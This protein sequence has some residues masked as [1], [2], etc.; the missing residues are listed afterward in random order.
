MAKVKHPMLARARAY[1]KQRRLLGYQLSDAGRIVDFA[2]FMDRVD[3]HGPLT[4]SRVMEWIGAVKQRKCNTQAGLLS[5]IRG[6][7]RY[8]VGFDAR[9]QVPPPGLLG[10]QYSR[11]R[12]HIFTQAQIRLILSRARALTPRTSALF[13]LTYETLI[14]LL[15]CTG[16]R[17]G[18]ARRLKPCDF[19]A[20]SGLLRVPRFKTSPERIIPL[21]PSAV[22]ALQRYAT[23]RQTQFP[24]AATFFVGAT[25]RMLN[26]QSTRYYFTMLSAGIRPN[27]DFAYTHLS[28]LRH[29]FASGWIAQWGRERAV[30]LHLALL[31]R[32]LGHSSFASTWWYVIA[33]PRA[34][35]EASGVFLH[36]HQH[37][38]PDSKT[39]R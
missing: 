36:F 32:Y 15:A 5:A 25:G 19:D 27:G 18:E 11:M 14:G 16:M 17:S 31:S 22:R 2:N 13:A 12:P 39:S 9:T 4:V 24:N 35:Q 37:A 1:I 3:P 33:D 29:S 6:F 34:L 23:M 10:P 26:K 8:C 30:S 28:D 21:H 38:A 7:A 20:D